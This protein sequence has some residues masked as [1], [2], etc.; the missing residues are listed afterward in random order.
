[1]LRFFRMSVSEK[2]G[3]ASGGATSGYTLV[4]S[5]AQMLPSRCAGIGPFAG[6]TSPYFSRSFSRAY[7]WSFTYSGRT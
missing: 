6:T 4:Q 2:P 5:C 7:A 1:M 3:S